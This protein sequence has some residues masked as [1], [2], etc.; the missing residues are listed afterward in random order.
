MPSPQTEIPNTVLMRFV[1]NL[2]LEELFPT[3]LLVPDIY[4]VL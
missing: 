3:E 1:L 4:E 2:L